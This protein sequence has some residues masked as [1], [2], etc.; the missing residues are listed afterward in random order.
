MKPKRY[1][2]WSKREIDLENPF[3]KEWYIKQVLLYGKSEDIRNI[4]W[5][6]IK[7]FLPHLNLPPDIKKFWEDYFN[8]S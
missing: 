6:E 7:A 1:I 8:A 3:Q 4:D 2:V 5:N